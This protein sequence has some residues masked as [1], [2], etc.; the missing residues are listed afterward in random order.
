MGTLE[1]SVW[2]EAAPERVWRIYADPARLPE[3][4]TGRPVIEDISGAPGEPGSSYVSR[5][6]RL[7]ARTTVQRA[8]APHELVTWT[9]AYLGLRFEV[10]S[11]LDG[12]G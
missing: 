12:P 4:Q 11:R 9:D 7:V 1:Y 3:W 5:R 2:I 8:A 10:T 6:G